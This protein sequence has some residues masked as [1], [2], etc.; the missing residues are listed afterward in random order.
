MPEGAGVSSK[1][2]DALR[3]IL[4]HSSTCILSYVFTIIIL[5]VVN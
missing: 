5:H 3:L 1:N 2:L 4:M